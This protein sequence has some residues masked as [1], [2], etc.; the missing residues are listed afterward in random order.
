MATDSKVSQQP[1]ASTLVGNELMPIIQ[2]GALKTVQANTFLAQLG[3]GGGGGAGGAPV[4]AFYVTT[5]PAAGLTTEKVLTSSTSVTVDTATT[6]IVSLKNAATT[7]DVVQAA[8]SV[9]TTIQPGVVTNAKLS[10]MAA[11]SVKVNATTALAAPTDLFVASNR[12]VG[13]GASGQVGALT[14]GTGLS[15]VVDVITPSSYWDGTVF[16]D[17]AGVEIATSGGTGVTLAEVWAAGGLRISGTGELIDGSNNVVSNTSTVADMTALVAL[18]AA[19]YDNFA[20]VPQT[21]V[22]R[23]VFLSNGVNFNPLNGAYIHAQV[24]TSV[25]KFVCANAVTWSIANNG[26]TVRLTGTAHGLTSASVGYALYATNAVTNWAAGTFHTITAV[27]TANTVDISTTFSSATGTPTFAGIT[28]AVPVLALTVP[29]LRANSRY[30]FET[31]LA[32]VAGGS[33]N[34]IRCDLGAVELNAI[35]FVATTNTFM[36]LRAGFMNLNDVSKQAGMYGKFTPGFTNGGDVVT[37]DGVSPNSAGVNTSTGTQVYT[38]YL[39]NS[40]VD[41]GHEMLGYTIRVEG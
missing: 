6:G 37:M 27:P 21:G 40:A 36:S 30:L 15:M 13:R 38:V 23:A 26:G 33:L 31:R 8:N 4:D 24:N 32:A 17:A 7:G 1:T 16:R 14:L 25:R 20:F 28:T 11:N 2:S 18:D 41:K 10:T 9:T 12:V 5:A 29:I 19:L 22:R 39:E 35:T 34:K 3:G